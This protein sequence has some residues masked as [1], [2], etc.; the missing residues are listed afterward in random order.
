MSM[1]HGLKAGL[2][3]W[4]ELVSVDAEI[5]AVHMMLERVSHRISNHRLTGRKGSVVVLF[6]LTDSRLT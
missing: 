4:A 5:Q 3:C 6:A 1:V 2:G